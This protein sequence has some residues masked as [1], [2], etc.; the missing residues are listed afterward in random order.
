MAI[1]I[2]EK[3]KKLNLN[4]EKVVFKVAR[5]IV[6]KDAELIEARLTSF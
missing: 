6:H 5:K 2:L 4:L 1:L 3:Y